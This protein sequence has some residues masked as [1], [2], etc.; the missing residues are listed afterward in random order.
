MPYRI[1]MQLLWTDDPNHTDDDQFEE[2]EAGGVT[3]VDSE[4]PEV[5]EKFNAAAEAAGIT[6]TTVEIA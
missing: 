5:A 1:S 3:F 6:T 2:L 4:G